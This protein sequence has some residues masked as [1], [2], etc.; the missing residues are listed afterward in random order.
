MTK[1]SSNPKKI[2]ESVSMAGL[3]ENWFDQTHTFSFTGNP[4]ELIP[5][6]VLPVVPGS[7]VEL[8]NVS[9]TRLP[10]LVAP[11]FVAAEAYVHYFYVSNR[12]VWES[13]D[14]WFEDPEG[15][16]FTVP[17]LTVEDG[18]SSDQ[19]ELLDYF[20]IPP[21]SGGED[22]LDIVAFPFAAFQKIYNDYYRPRP[23]QDPVPFELPQAGGNVGGTV[24]SQ[25]LERRFRS[26]EHDY[27]TSMLTEPLVAPTVN[28]PL[29]INVNP[30]W[31]PD[32]ANP[33]FINSAGIPIHDGDVLQSAG[34]LKVNTAGALPVDSA[35]FDPD[36]S[37]VAE[38]T[39]NQLREA[40]ARMRYLEKMGRVGGEY[41]E[42]IQALYNRRISD[43]RL[44]RA[45]YITGTK[46][47]LI[48][49]PVL[50]TAGSDAG[51][52]DQGGHAFAAGKSHGGSFE[53]EEHGY[54]IG[55][56]SMI[57]K[58]VYKQGVHRSYRAFTREDYLIPDMANI[59]EQAV[60]SYEINAYKEPQNDLTT[61]GYLP[62]YTHMK[63][64]QS[65]IAGEFRTVLQHYCVVKEYSG[66]PTLDISF[67][68]V[69]P[70]ILDDILVSGSFNNHCLW[71]NMLHGIKH[72]LPLPVYSDPI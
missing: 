24:R 71:V 43:A 50:S 65:A 63:E 62:N 59:G 69:P 57:P 44:Q 32:G 18:L 28:I 72:R 25:L 9:L 68:Q 15:S 48:I 30:T 5:C 17:V 8:D 66:V 13:F 67:V 38:G 61:I 55:I 70:Q 53:A 2:Y 34:I 22:E 27:H 12:V 6:L 49:N 21:I 51:L 4:G 23:F 7:R 40:Y 20:R 36:G 52:A 35:A 46:M 45:E 47:D 3:S 41:Y 39:V 58:P 1:M 54:I 19:Y 26:W 10:P 60:Y 42:I 11:A 56:Y 31:G 14:E 64:I 16:G 29:T 33:K 37:L